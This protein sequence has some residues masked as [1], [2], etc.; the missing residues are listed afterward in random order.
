MNPPI[1]KDG[2]Y[3]TRSGFPVRIYATDAG[4]NYPVHGAFLKDGEWIQNDWC[5][6]GKFDRSDTTPDGL[7]L[8]PKP[9]VHKISMWGNVYLFNGKAQLGDLCFTKEQAQKKIPIYDRIALAH[10]ELDVREGEGLE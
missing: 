8:I 9:K 2:E 6:S 3:T 5:I 4:G 10:I 1:T 7:D